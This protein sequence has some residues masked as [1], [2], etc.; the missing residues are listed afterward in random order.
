MGVSPTGQQQDR[1]IE[2]A[3]G[4]HALPWQHLDLPDAAGRLIDARLWLRER[5]GRFHKWSRTDHL[6]FRGP[7]DRVFLIDRQAGALRFGDGRTGRIPVPDPR[8]DGTPLRVRWYIGGGIVGVGGTT[9]N[10]TAPQ[11]PDIWAENLVPA[12]GGGD[13]ESTAEARTRAAAGVRERHRAVTPEDYQTVAEETPGVGVARA[14]VAVGVHP[15]H[16]CARVPGAVTVSVVPHAPRDPDDWR[17]D[18]F[19]RA[20]LPDPGALR[21]VRERLQTARLL[22]ADVVVEPPQYR[23]A[24]LRID[25]EGAPADPEGLRARIGDRLLRFVDPLAGGEDGNGWPFGEPLR[26]SALLRIAQQAAGPDAAVTAVAIWTGH[27]QTSSRGTS[28]Q[29]GHWEDC[30]DVPIG[31]RALVHLEDAEV[32]FGA[33]QLERQGLQ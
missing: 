4:W 26:P 19:V 24:R 32:R 21:A 25:V 14:H 18:D 3:Q 5:D 23:R 11:H 8:D 20:P 30:V 10:W 13:A 33:A 31:A 27:T 7:A 1:L 6:A 12:T 15:A 17:R 22:G 28:T 29:E 9:S 2:Q 16:P